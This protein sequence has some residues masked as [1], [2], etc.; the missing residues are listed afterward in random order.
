MTVYEHY[1]DVPCI[2][3]GHPECTDAGIWGEPCPP[4]CNCRW[5]TPE[6]HAPGP[7]VPA[8]AA[9]PVIHKM[10]CPR[11]DIAFAYRPDQPHYPGPVFFELIGVFRPTP[12]TLAWADARYLAGVSQAEGESAAIADFEAEFP[13]SAAS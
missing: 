6:G 8:T 2:S 12:E 13:E 9:H 1:H 3:C 10:E 5:R 11:C 4:G 7:D